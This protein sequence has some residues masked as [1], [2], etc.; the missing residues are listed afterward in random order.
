M[1]VDAISGDERTDCRISLGGLCRVL[2]MLPGVLGEHVGYL[3]GKGGEAHAIVMARNVA[4]SPVE[5][6]ADARDTYVAHVVAETLGLEV[7]AVYHTHPG[8]YPYPSARD[9]SGMRL[10]PV[11]WVIASRHGIAAYRLID[12][13]VVECTVQC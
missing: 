2:V 7:V 12:E 4:S 13:E 5:F 6:E 10:W 11:T 1:V 3:I 9:R 8:G